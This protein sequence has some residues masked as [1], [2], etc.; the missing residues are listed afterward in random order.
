[1]LWKLD[2]KLSTCMVSELGMCPSS[3]HESAPNLASKNVCTYLL[4]V[5]WIVGAMFPQVSVC[6]GHV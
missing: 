5:I 3:L 2:L 1:M 6:S 4:E